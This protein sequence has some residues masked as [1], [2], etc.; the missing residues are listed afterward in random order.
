MKKFNQNKILSVILLLGVAFS[1]ITV[2]TA[3]QPNP[4]HGIN[5]LGGVTTGDVLYG[6]GLD[7]V[8]ALTAAATGNALISG[9]TPSWGKVGLT[10]HV[11]GILPTANGGTGMAF[12]TVA[13]PTIARIFTFPDAAATVLTSNAAVTVAQGG[14]GAAPGAGD[15]VLV[16]DSTSAGTWRAIPDCSGNGKALRYTAS[17]NTFDCNTLQFYNQSVAVQTPAVTDTYLVGSNVAIPAVGLQAGTRYHMIFNVTK[18]AAGVVAPILNVRYGTGAATTDASKCAITFAAQTAVID[19]GT[20]EVWVTFRTIGAG[21]AAVVQC[22]GQIRHSGQTATPFSTVGLS[23]LT[24][25]TK[26][27]TSAGFDS[28]VANSKIGASITTGTSAAWT[29]QLVQAELT[30]LN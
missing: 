7:A 13:G 15:Q 17:T 16:A 29:I 25:D 23:V 28:T 10:T 18:T 4:G 24:S 19:V 2:V 5:T 12:F 11:S 1:V 21:T 22:V 6:S 30:N 9:T 3:V 14:T 20:V 27:V 8:S 26:V